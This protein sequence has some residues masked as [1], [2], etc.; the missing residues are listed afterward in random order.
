MDVSFR[1]YDEILVSQNDFV[2]RVNDYEKLIKDDELEY[3]EPQKN[4]TI[5]KPFHFYKKFAIDTACLTR[6]KNPQS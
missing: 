4:F 2:I 3:Q 6:K 1:L 5:G